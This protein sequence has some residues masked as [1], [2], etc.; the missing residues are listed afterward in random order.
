MFFFFPVNWMELEISDN[1]VTVL[2][3]LTDNIVTML[4]EINQ[5]WKHR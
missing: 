3:A 1:I 2:N 4:N 5:T